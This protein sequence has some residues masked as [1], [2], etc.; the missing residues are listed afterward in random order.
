MDLGVQKKKHKL[1]LDICYIGPGFGSALGAH[2][3]FSVDLM[4]SF[5]GGGEY[6]HMDLSKNFKM[7]TKSRKF[8]SALWTIPVDP[9]LHM[10]KVHP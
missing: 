1:K 6:Q 2:P 7:D 8:W 10:L 5:G 3:V 4:P 9:S